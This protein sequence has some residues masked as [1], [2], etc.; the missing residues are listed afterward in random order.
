M[1]KLQG[2]R[3]QNEVERLEIGTQSVSVKM[4]VIMGVVN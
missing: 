4:G 2:C 3:K 1:H